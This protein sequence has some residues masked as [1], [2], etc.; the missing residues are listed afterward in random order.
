MRFDKVYEEKDTDEKQY[1][2]LLTTMSHRVAVSHHADTCRPLIKKPRVD[3][4]EI[5]GQSRSV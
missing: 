4:C 5:T 2:E 1:Q 3:W